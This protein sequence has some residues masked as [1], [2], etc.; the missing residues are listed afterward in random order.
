MTR[1]P[2]RRHPGLAEEWGCRAIE[3]LTE[4]GVVAPQCLPRSASRQRELLEV[5]RPRDQRAAK[6]DKGTSLRPVERPVPSTPH[7]NRLRDAADF[8]V[9]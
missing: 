4:Q 2:G 6:H 8:L 7:W 5:F 9:G 1:S 3:L